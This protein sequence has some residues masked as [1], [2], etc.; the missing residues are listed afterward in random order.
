M[1]E[2]IGALAHDGG[3][4]S[5]D[6]RKR[7]LERLLAKLLRDV[8]GATPQEARGVGRGR[9]SMP[10]RLDGLEEPVER[11]AIARGHGRLPRKMI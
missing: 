11:R 8:L 10:M 3:A 5:G 2:Q 1:I 7:R 4:P 6:G 9:I